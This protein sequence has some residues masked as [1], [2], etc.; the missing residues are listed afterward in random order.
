VQTINENFNNLTTGNATF[1]QSG[2]SVVLPPMNTPPSPPP[3]MIVYAEAGDA[4]NRYVS[5]NSGGNKDT[6]QYFSCSTNCCSDRK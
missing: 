1:P 3:M 2:W 4:T 6:S 5:S